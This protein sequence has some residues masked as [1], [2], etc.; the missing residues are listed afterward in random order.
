[1]LPIPQRGHQ[2]SGNSKRISY[3][4]NDVTFLASGADTAGAY[5]LLEFV[6]AP[7]P[8]RVPPPHRHP[9]LDEG[10]YVIEGAL[11][12]LLGDQTVT[13][14]AGEYCHVP[15]GVV[16]QPVNPG[17]EP[18]RYL[19]LCV[20]AGLENNFAELGEVYTAPGGPERSRLMALYEKH[21]VQLA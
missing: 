1:M 6:T 17:N 3:G 16:H 12:M 13:V 7:N 11:T 5:A 14:A 20:P 15:R 21:D 9:N 18:V 10:F 19:V 4:G 8:G 2:H